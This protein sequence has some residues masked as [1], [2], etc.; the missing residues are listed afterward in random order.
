MVVAAVAVEE[1]VQ[2]IEA[3]VP[4]PKARTVRTRL[5]KGGVEQ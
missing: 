5:R 1:E 2:G 4:A 3:G